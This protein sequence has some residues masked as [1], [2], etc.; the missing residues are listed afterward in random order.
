MT[1][2]WTVGEVLSH[3]RMP[4]SETDGVTEPRLQC[5]LLYTQIILSYHTTW[6]A[7]KCHPCVS[8]TGV[9][10]TFGANINDVSVSIT[11]RCPVILL[12]VRSGRDNVVTSANARDG[13]LP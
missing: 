8:N 11:Q 2:G 3:E 13:S 10:K 5:E 6:C 12:S 1:A 4:A 9:I 7:T